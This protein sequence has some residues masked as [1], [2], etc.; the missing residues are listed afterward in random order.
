MYPNDKRK[1]Y[2]YF[3]KIANLINN[4]FY[5][6]IHSTNNNLNESYNN[7]K[8]WKLIAANYNMTISVL[9]YLKK[10]YEKIDI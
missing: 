9:K 5:Y 8:N 1:K 10:Q 3:Y 7:L 6:G 2:N 4:H